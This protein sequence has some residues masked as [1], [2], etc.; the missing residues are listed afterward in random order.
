MI[1]LRTPSFR[2][3]AYQTKDQQ[4]TSYLHGLVNDLNFALENVDADIQTLKKQEPVSGAPEQYVIS[5]NGKSGV[6]E[7]ESGGFS[8]IA[9]VK[10]T[11]TG[12]VITITDESGTTRATVSNG[13]KG[14]KGDQG[15]Q[16]E[17]GIQGIQGEK[18]DT[19]A[20][21]A[22]GD[23]GDQGIQ[24]EKGDTGAQ[25]ATGEKGEKGD[26]GAKGDKGDKG[27]AFTYDDFTP[28]QLAALKGE[29]G[30]K[31][32]T[33]AKGDKGDTGA[34]GDKGDTGDNGVSVTHSWS[35]TTLT[36]TSASGT[37]SADLKGAKGDTGAT[38]AQGAQGEA[39]HSPVVTAS[40]SGTVT[41]ISVDGA[42]IATVNDGEKGGTGADGYSP[43]ASVEQTS[44]GA[45]ITITDKSGTTTAEVKNGAG[46]GASFDEIY[47]VGSIYLSASSTSPASLFGGTWEQL[48]DT[49]LL[50]AGDSYT[51]GD[52][53][54]EAEHTLTAD[55][56]PS[57]RH[58]M[59]AAQYSNGSNSVPRAMYVYKDYGQTASWISA[60]G[61]ANWMNLTGGGAAHNNMPPYLTVYMW[62]RVG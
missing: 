62:Q 36:V 5:V 3:N 9:N 26:T 32:D 8:P 35:G 60:V 23:K 7:V 14:E 44:T 25:G 24:G 43:S 30:D 13:A 51:A 39:G 56:M 34:K 27:D 11:D 33:G 31:G 29:K 18:G 50:A 61:Q 2:D 57:H 48:K 22:K 53:G 10:Q 55:E 54:G 45:T 58:A 52:M 37:S 41:T 1:S 49:F 28:E 21:G 20:T 12:A 4:I 6:V 59:G 19:G 40:K 42:A 47:P 15:I 46:G 16:G 38:G 17:Q